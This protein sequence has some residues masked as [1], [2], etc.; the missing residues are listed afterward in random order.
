[1][2]N[3]IMNQEN[4]LKLLFIINPASGNNKR[5]WNKLI[6]NYFS[7]YNYTIELYHLT[8][9]CSVKT[10]DSKIKRFLPNQVIAVGGDGT[11]K[12]V[13]ECILQKNIP[14]GILPAGS[15]NGLAKEL[16]IDEDPT[17]ALD[18]LTKGNLQKIHITKINNHLCIH[19]SDIGLNAYAMKHFKYQGVRG[20]WGY[21]RASLKV[22]WQNPI[23]EIEMQNDEK[24]F[25][26]KAEMIVI[27]NGTQYGSGAIIN[28][29]GKLNDTH[30]EVITI[31][32]ISFLEVFKMIV[33]HAPYDSSKTE[34]FQTNTLSMRSKKRVH[35]QVD[36]EYIGK[37]YE[38]KAFLIPDALQI[39][40]PNAL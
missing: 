6:T 27:A 15:A 26:I 35:F 29:I 4:S 20:M 17:K 40:V 24:A 14:L 22:L 36:G 37:V 2:N 19:L 12:M 7:S 18:I 21:L 28:P 33:S 34:I 38:I 13:A 31:K 23:M 16:K 11:I 1:M 30:F 25:K 32:K 39:I 10:L 3:E 8:K 5:D 9:N